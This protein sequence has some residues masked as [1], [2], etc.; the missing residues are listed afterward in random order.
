MK[1]IVVLLANGARLN[2]DIKEE[3]VN[4]FKDNIIKGIKGIFSGPNEK[5]C[6]INI[7]HIIQV[8]IVDPEDLEKEEAAKKEAIETAKSSKEEK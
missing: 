3:D 7:D 8:V 4:D 6:W 5:F 2:F 1:K